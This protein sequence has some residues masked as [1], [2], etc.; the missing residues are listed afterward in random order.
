M[1]FYTV[2][3]K[4]DE[5]TKHHEDYMN[6]GKSVYAGE[7]FDTRK[8]AAERKKFLKQKYPNMEF[9]IESETM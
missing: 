2:E 6:F 9:V 7:G 8:D 4:A 3:P 5:Y 1:K